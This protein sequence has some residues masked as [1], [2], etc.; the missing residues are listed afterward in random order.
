MNI[1]CSQVLEF[2]CQNNSDL[3]L[4]HVLEHWLTRTPPPTLNGLIEALKSPAVGR[5]DIASTLEAH[6]AT[7]V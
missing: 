1:S 3:C 5:D 2:D 6:N 7:A 4:T